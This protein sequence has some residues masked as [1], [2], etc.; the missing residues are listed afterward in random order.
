MRGGRRLLGAT[1]LAGALLPALAESPPARLEP[2]TGKLDH[3]VAAEERP[4]VNRPRNYCWL[5]RLPGTG[6]DSVARLIAYECT[7]IT[8]LPWFK[9]SYSDWRACT[10]E[11]AQGTASPL[12][13][14]AIRT[15]C[16]ELFGG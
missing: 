7:K 11:R 12:A 8:A 13:A 4:A 5:D 14:S 16:I 15:A 10:M 1:L 6:T 2:F 3:E 9:P